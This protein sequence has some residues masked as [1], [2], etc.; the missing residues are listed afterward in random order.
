MHSAL[1]S[2]N[3]HSCVCI[4]THGDL[5]AVG[6]KCGRVSLYSASTMALLHV[7]ALSSFT[8]NQHGH[9]PDQ[10]HFKAGSKGLKSKEEA[11]SSNQSIRSVKFVSNGCFLVILRVDDVLFVLPTKGTA[12]SKVSNTSSSMG[13]ARP[14]P[15]HLKASTTPYTVYPVQGDD[16][17]FCVVRRHSVF[18]YAIQR[19]EDGAFH[20]M[21]IG[22]MRLSA[23]RFF[24][25]KQGSSSSSE[26]REGMTSRALVAA[27]TRSYPIRIRALHVV[28]EAIGSAGS[29]KIPS[30]RVTVVG[31]LA[32][33]GWDR[34]SGFLFAGNVEVNNVYETNEKGCHYDLQLFTC[35]SLGALGHSFSQNFSLLAA[36]CGDSICVFDCNRLH[37]SLKVVRANALTIASEEDSAAAHD[38]SSDD[39]N[40][41]RAVGTKGRIVRAVFNHRDLVS[42]CCVGIFV[43]NTDAYHGLGPVSHT[44]IALEQRATSG[45]RE[46]QQPMFVYAHSPHSPAVYQVVV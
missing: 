43:V 8:T 30:F 35:A 16:D 42:S 26:Q 12:F 1:D 3:M 17:S 31:S 28:R 2:R 46:T 4:D 40:W 24:D 22:S 6:S 20:A 45:A 37:E 33:M 19:R 39:I 13:V 9:K 18:L 11:H 15:L 44:S 10:H 5:M 14:V 41:R 38:E 27:A 36:Q 29:K 23:M 25:D 21:R 7:V 34:A 32:Q